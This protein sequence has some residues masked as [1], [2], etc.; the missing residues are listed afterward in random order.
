MPPPGENVENRLYST[1]YL[2]LVCTIL[3]C[4]M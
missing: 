1:Y 2:E 3:E 4:I